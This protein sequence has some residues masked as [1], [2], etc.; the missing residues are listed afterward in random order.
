MNIVFISNFLTHHQLPFSLEMLKYKEH[1][2]TF[3]ATGPIEEEKLQLGYADLN[4][5]YDF[6]LCAYENAE[7]K[8]KALEL[9]S[10][11]DILITGSSPDY[12][13]ANRLKQKK[14]TF[15]YG[16]R[17]FKE[18]FTFKNV[19]RRVASMLKHVIP[20][21]NKNHYLL[22]ASAYMPNDCRLF[23]CFKNRMYRWGYF[24]EV[25]EN[26]LDELIAKK[27]KN[28]LLWVGR[29][30]DWKHPEYAVRLAKYLKELNFNFELNM[31]GCGNL[32]ADIAGMI[33]R[34]NLTDCVHMLGSMAPE[35]VREHM[36]QAEIFL[37][38]SD[39]REGWGAVLNESMNSGCAVVA[40]SAIGAVP[41][42]LEDGDNGLIYSDGDFNAFCQK[43]ISLLENHQKAEDIGRN[44]YKTLSEQ[45]NPKNAAER[46]VK[47]SESLSNERAD[48]LFEHGVCSKIK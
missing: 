46:L 1:N 41:F 29:M 20:Y 13:F 40:S 24:P 9:C 16:E 38:T 14:L 28:K 44:A 34:E 12:Y 18:P 6:V 7:N 4:H 8:S 42:L 30:I 35:K 19:F 10:S 39:R 3:I 37:F 33:K 17:F 23:G 21:Q 43:V 27:Q 36:E 5:Q 47:L 48:D 2:Y 31:I 11:C 15:K 25:K 45:W 26:N 22:C 32:E